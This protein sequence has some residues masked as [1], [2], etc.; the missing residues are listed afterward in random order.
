MQL[1]AVGDM[2]GQSVA[3]AQI[4]KATDLGRQTVYRIMDDPESAEGVLASWQL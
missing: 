3:I 2:L 1:G 4:A